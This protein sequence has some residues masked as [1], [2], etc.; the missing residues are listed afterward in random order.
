MVSMEQIKTGL[1][2]YLD[3]EF[4][5]KLPRGDFRQN[6]KAGGA[7]A[8]CV[9][10]IRRLDALL[11]AYAAKAGLD[12][13][14]AIDASGGVDLDGL[15]D[16]VRPQVGPEGLT[17]EAPVLGE[18]TIYREDLDKLAGYIREA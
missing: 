6:L 10:A 16:A 11:P 12:K 17:V 4:A 1:T 8:W 18:I 14:G 13:L 5:P 2:R 7:I 9:Y 15:L 3:A